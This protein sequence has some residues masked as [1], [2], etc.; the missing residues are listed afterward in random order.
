VAKQRCMACGVE[1]WGT[2]R[3]G[4]QPYCPSGHPQLRN[5]RVTVKA[6][7]YVEHEVYA[8]SPEQAIVK[9]TAFAA[10]NPDE[11]MIEDWYVY[12][13]PVEVDPLTGME[14]GV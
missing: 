9:A 6:S 1:L 10:E 11:A 2:A 4:E 14:S 8:A 5:Y 7:A 13:E 12:D 3:E